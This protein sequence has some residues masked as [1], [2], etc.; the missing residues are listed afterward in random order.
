MPLHC[1][2]NLGCPK[3]VY[4]GPDCIPFPN[5]IYYHCLIVLAFA[6]PQNIVEH[7]HVSDLNCLILLQG[8]LS[9]LCLHSSQLTLSYVSVSMSHRLKTF[10]T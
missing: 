4:L 8:H 10:S 9:Q 6:D 2:V 3:L 7:S 5:D 1:S